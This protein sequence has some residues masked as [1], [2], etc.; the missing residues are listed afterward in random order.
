M[1]STGIFPEYN[2]DTD[3]VRYNDINEIQAFINEVSSD[4]DDSINYLYDNVYTEVAN[5]TQTKK[6]VSKKI[7]NK[8]D[9]EYIISMTHDKASEKSTI[10]ELFGDFGEGPKFNPYDTI[11]IPANKFG[12]LSKINKSITS[13][14]KSN[15]T[16]FTTTI[17]L[18]IFNK[19][20]IE[21]LS[22]ILGYIN[23]PITADVYEDINQKISYALMEDKITVEQLKDF[24]TQSQILMGCCSA[25][26]S[27][28]TDLIFSME[29]KISKKKQELEKKYGS[30]LDHADLIT[31]KAYENEL[32]AYAQDLLK[33][34]EAVDM[35]NSGARSS[36][37][38]NFKNMYLTRGPIK[39]TDG[40]YKVIRNSYIEGLNKE[41]FADVADAAVQGPYD[42]SQRTA[43]GGYL[44]RQLVASV[45]HI[46]ILP[47]GSDCGTKDHINVLLTKKNSK[48]WLYSFVIENNGSLTELTT[49]NIDKYIGK[50]VKL[51]YSMMCKAKNGG[52]CEKCAG[53]LYNR[54]GIT[55]VGV[56]GSILGSSLKN[57]LMKSFHNSTLNLYEVKPED[58]FQ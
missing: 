5:S 29:D 31:A 45:A 16:P 23:T 1:I 36:W 50:T 37:G 27:S 47:K 22:D 54:I 2:E 15:K 3:S 20:F 9:I 39:H 7:T 40:T 14:K 46:K 11:D 8:D 13:S 43:S 24:I 17:G 19:S 12:G 58:I 32:I 4:E 34:D 51:R 49:D 41:D 10:M 21:P 57:A 55:N 53:T 44:E 28:H 38:N 26:A 48:Q 35:Y 30:K 33:D 6:R 56:A 42:R 25:L 18:W 52:I